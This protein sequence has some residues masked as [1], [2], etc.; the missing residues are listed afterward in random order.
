[1]NVTRVAGC[2]GVGVVVCE[3]GVGAGVESSHDVT[4]RS[5][6]DKPTTVRGLMVPLQ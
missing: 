6:N 4:P 1:M 5:M 3:T 2:A